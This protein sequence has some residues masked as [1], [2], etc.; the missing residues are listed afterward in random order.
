MAKVKER[1]SD[2]LFFFKLFE[3]GKVPDALLRE[4]SEMMDTPLIQIT[5][6]LYLKN[7]DQGFLHGLYILM[8][9]IWI[10]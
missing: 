10:V 6:F 4:V 9:F 1:K 2:H 8:A 3:V 7:K 5:L